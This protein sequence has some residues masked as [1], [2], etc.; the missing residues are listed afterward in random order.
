MKALKHVEFEALVD[1]CNQ[2]SFFN[3]NKTTD[4]GPERRSH[5]STESAPHLL[6]TYLTS[7]DTF[8]QPRQGGKSALDCPAQKAR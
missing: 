7:G 6:S 1:C 8:V 4:S 3:R 5:S 2:Y